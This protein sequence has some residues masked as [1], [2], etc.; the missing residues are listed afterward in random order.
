MKRKIQKHKSIIAYMF[1]GVLTTLINW[2]SYFLC[3]NIV[4]IPNVLSTIIAW[5]LAVEFAF[6]T[7]KLWVFDSKTFNKNV[8][9]H[10]MWTFLAARLITEILDIT[11]MYFA[12]DI[13]AL[14]STVWKLISNIIVILLNYIFSKFIIFKKS[15]PTTPIDESCRSNMMYISIHY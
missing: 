6:I 5:V 2:G 15:T 7:N 1:F 12:V 13:F 4:H 10:E 11:I 9:L 3:Y 8:L 14:N